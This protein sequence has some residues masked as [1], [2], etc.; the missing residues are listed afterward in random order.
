MKEFL[1]NAE[2]KELM[3]SVDEI[4]SS[5]K[6]FS[7]IEDEQGNQYVDLV[8]E[9][10]GVLGIALVGYTYILERAGIRFYSLAGTSAGAINTMMLAALGRLEE[11]KSEKILEV[12]S[13]KVLFDLVDGGSAVRKL[14]QKAIKGQSGIGWVIAWNIRRLYRLLTKRLGLNPGKDFEKWI[15]DEL[16]KANIRNMGDILQLRKQ[17]P[18]GLKHVLGS[19]IEG[20]SPQLAIIA[21]DITTHSKVEFPRMSELFFADPHSVPPASLVRTSMSIPLFFEPVTI[22][23]I[24]NQGTTQDH[25]WI[26]HCSYHGPVPPT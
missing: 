16:N 15:T 25:K 9:G 11:P 12:L 5:K 8:Q 18:K 6:R 7:D 1:E 10:G 3:S 24:P 19:D 17:Q 20:M 23:D 13:N 26:Q 21:A 4:V 14:V 22:K 2:L